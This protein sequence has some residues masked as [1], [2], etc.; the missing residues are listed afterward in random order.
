MRDARRF[1]PERESKPCVMKVALLQRAAARIVFTAVHIAM[2]LHHVAVTVLLVGWIVLPLLRALRLHRLH[3]WLSPHEARFAHPELTSVVCD[4]RGAGARFFNVAPGVV[5]PD[6][7]KT[8]MSLA[9]S[10]PIYGAHASTIVSFLARVLVLP[11]FAEMGIW[12]EI[13]EASDGCRVALD[14]L[15]SPA[16]IAQRRIVPR[17]LVVIVPGLNSDIDDC[18]I[19]S[20]FN[21]L[22]RDG[23][24]DAVM[25]NTRGYG[26][27]LEAHNK[28]FHAG[29]TS[30]L[31]AVV[32]RHLVPGALRRRYGIHAPP[33]STT[34]AT[35]A[36]APSPPPLCFVAFSMGSNT[37]AKFLAEEGPS[38]AYTPTLGAKA[39]DDDRGD[40][41]ASS[42]VGSTRLAVKRL[43]S[44]PAAARRSFAALETPTKPREAR[45]GATASAPPSSP[46][47]AQATARCS[48]SRGGVQAPTTAVEQQQQQQQHA[49]NISPHAAWRP[50]VTCA[51]S[52][53]GPWNLISTV[54]HL[55]GLLNHFVY[56]INMVGNVRDMVLRNLRPHAGSASSVGA[57]LDGVALQSRM[58]EFDEEHTAPLHGYRSAAHYY[59]TSQAFD[60]LRGV[61]VPLLAIST[62]DD[63]VGGTARLDEQWDAV[64]HE[65]G[66][67][68][69]VRIPGGGH[70][71]AMSSPVEEWRDAMTPV[72]RIVI[73]QLLPRVL[74]HLR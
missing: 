69:Y 65:N 70:L 35:G 62:L 54:Y 73:G 28:P 37:L 43:T 22:P 68:V 9:Y 21:K 71:G 27:P 36:A 57:N 14:W 23:S 31:R 29:F 30:D 38:I 72:E 48:K 61:A 66:N 59:A 1:P 40:D 45:D 39:C 15:F 67:V 3:R 8:N 20:F 58:P 32:Y 18:Y 56:Q 17:L 42:G 26:A 51:V 52:V 55:G 12:R 11:T 16:V 63:P 4:R 33:N 60:R 41:N 6:N 47:P 74:S 24:I 49:N 34:Q 50:Q 2:H 44:A 53:C 7:S 10:G 46:L 64:A 13:V 5:F 25:V 19:R